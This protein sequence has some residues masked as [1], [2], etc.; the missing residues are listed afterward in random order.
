MKFL[1]ALILSAVF[2]L[3]STV[4]LACDRLIS[5]K[6]RS[7]NKGQS[8]RAKKQAKNS[9]VRKDSKKVARHKKTTKK[10]KIARHKKI[11]ELPPKFVQAKPVKDD[12]LSL[13]TMLA[14]SVREPSSEGDGVP[15]PEIPPMETTPEEVHLDF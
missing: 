11:K 4:S 15:L 8:L 10:T 1:L 2:L 12:E 13:D 7:Q 3:S 5:T 14:T 9:K 6:G